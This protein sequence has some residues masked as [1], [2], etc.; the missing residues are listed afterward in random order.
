MDPVDLLALGLNPG[1]NTCRSRT[2]R[3]TLL[4]DRV[5]R[6]MTAVEINFKDDRGA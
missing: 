6:Q 4:N 3:L 5:I 1:E 2:L